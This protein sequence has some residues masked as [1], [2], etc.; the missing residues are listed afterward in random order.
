[1]I[2]TMRE[3]VRFCVYDKPKP[4]GSKR[5]FA[6]PV[7]GQPGKS[8]VVITDSCKGGPAWRTAV[9]DAARKVYKDNPVQGESLA[10]KFIFYVRRP[11]SHFRTGRYS[12]FLRDSAP[13]DPITRPDLLKLARAAEDALTGII[14]DDDSRT[15]KM[16]LEERYGNVAG[17]QIIVIVGG[18]N[19]DEGREEFG[20]YDAGRTVK[21]TAND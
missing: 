1:M 15:V 2:E 8:R 14:Y 11:K 7:K 4:A 20:S 13:Q 6:I 16:H 12:A 19:G 3:L 17:V 10:V 21:E 9:Q 18:K 5:G